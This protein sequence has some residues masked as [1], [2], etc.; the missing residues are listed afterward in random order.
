MQRTLDVSG[1][2]RTIHTT[3]GIDTRT[4]AVYLRNLK[5][6]ETFLPNGF[7]AELGEDMWHQLV[8]APQLWDQGTWRSGFH[9]GDVT[10][11]LTEAV[12]ERVNAPK[13][14][15]RCG[16][17]MCAAGWVDELAGADWVVDNTILQKG[18]VTNHTESVLLPRADYVAWCERVGLTRETQEIATLS[19]NLQYRL[20]ERGFTDATHVVT[21]AMVYSLVRLGLRDDYV[22]MYSASNGYAALRAKLDAYIQYGDLALDD[23]R[24]IVEAR[25]FADERE[26]VYVDEVHGS[27]GGDYHRWAL[28]T[29]EREPA[30]V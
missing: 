19:E 18:Y 29:L 3:N 1:K 22:G 23:Q 6:Y 14:T 9:L 12:R 10:T 25:H 24:T 16:T 26:E 17:V 28:A 8:V 15:T 27:F 21:S 7:N 30:N 13:K 20:K 4:T 2:T 11:E 5:P